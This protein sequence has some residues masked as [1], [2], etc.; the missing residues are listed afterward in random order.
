VV[1]SSSEVVWHELE[2][3]SYRAD[4][5]LWRE[6][7]SRAAGGGSARVLE[8]GAGAGRVAL[9][10]ARAG[11]RVTA[12]DIDPEL[13]DALK[14]HAG[15]AGVEV[16]CAD[17]RTFDLARGDFDLCVVAMQTVQLLGGSDERVAFLRRARAHLR[18]RGTL[19]L[20]IVTEVEPFDC[21]DGEAGPSAEIARVRGALYVSRAT[22]VCVG[23]ERM[24]IERERRI[25]PERRAAEVTERSVVELHRVDA[26]ELE[27]EAIEAGLRCDCSTELAPTEEHVGSTVVVLSG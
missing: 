23:A 17:A 9:D 1:V 6:L 2:C 4:L 21:A 13:L 14:G 22:R 7:A 18:E 20:A 24:V 11:H 3:G 25:V 5:P 8:V 27:R 19:A 15:G 12:L 16:V 26:P 10:L